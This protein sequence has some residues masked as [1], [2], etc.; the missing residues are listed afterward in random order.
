MRYLV[1]GGVAVNLYGYLRYTGDVD[2]LVPFDDENLKKIK[3]IID[4]IDGIDVLVE[5]SRKFDEFFAKKLVKR[6]DNVRIPVV[7]IE[8]LIVTKRKKADFFN[9]MDRLVLKVIVDLKNGGL[10]AESMVKNEFDL[11][12][13]KF[14]IKSSTRSRL[15]WLDS[16]LKFGK[17]FELKGKVKKS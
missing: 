6:C 12:A 10:N 17:Q 13:L 14:W 7:S 4:K 16:A 15:D 11:E 2:L 3:S 8:D 5:K 1:V 9:R